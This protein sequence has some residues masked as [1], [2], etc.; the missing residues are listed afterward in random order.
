[1]PPEAGEGPEEPWLA[2][3]RD[4]LAMAEALAAGG[5]PGWGVC[6]HVQQAVEKALK[7]LLV[8]GGLDPPRTHNLLRL[9]DAVEA[10]L[11]AD[12]DTDLLASLTLWSSQQR[13]PAD[14]VE[15]T[16]SD[17]TEALELGQRTLEV[18]EARMR[19]GGG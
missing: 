12:T 3:A 16:P 17:V 1:V 7:A 11:F 19:R 14:Q 13:Y 8:A 6:Y 4:D 15:P 9:Q 10:P 5:L 2:K 18:V